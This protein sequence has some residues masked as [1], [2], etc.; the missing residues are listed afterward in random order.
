VKAVR[1]SFALATA[2]AALVPASA[3]SALAPLEDPIGPVDWPAPIEA[4]DAGR[5]DPKPC[6]TRE[7]VA[8]ARRW[9]DDREGTIS[10]AVLDECKRL[11]GDHRYR[12]HLSASVVKVML[13]VA[14]LRQDGVR[15]D[16]LTDEERA[17]LEPMITMSDNER[18]NQVYGIVGEDGLY[19]LAAA[20]GMR[21]F[22]TM[23]AWGGSEITAGDQATF[24]GRIERYVPRRHEKY[25]LS[26]MANVIGPQRW[27]VPRM[28][29]PGWEIHLKGGWSPQSS[30][31]GWRVNQ[32]ALLRDGDRRLSLAI[33][34]SDQLGYAYGR[35]SI[36]GVARRL[37]A[38][39]GPR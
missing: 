36:Q 32:V 25:V 9:A 34:T 16:E 18:A 14:Y 31:G 27:G 3:A 15:D 10:F 5:A 24:V 26:L 38:S 8:E 28:D 33:L 23:P 1:A 17:M 35:E 30:G 4:G 39:Y 12:V 6:M 19:E 2:V 11:V 7:R 22:T 21:H 20:A 13:L 29:L 37:L